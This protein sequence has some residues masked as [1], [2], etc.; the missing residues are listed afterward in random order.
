M[1]TIFL[2]F[3]ISQ[4]EPPTISINTKTGEIIVGMIPFEEVTSLKEQMFQMPEKE[5]ENSDIP[6]VQT[7]PEEHPMFQFQTLESPMEKILNP[8]NL[9]QSL[10]DAWS[11]L[12][13][14]VHQHQTKELDSEQIKKLNADIKMHSVDTLVL[15]DVL[16]DENVVFR[17][18][19]L[20]PSAGKKI[21][22][23]LLSIVYNLSIKNYQHAV[24]NMVRISHF[25]SV[26]TTICKDSEPF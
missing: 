25:I 16:H 23:E 19:H 8:C 24:F 1:L 10:S 12:A 13:G 9:L 4:C 18:K 5:P 20:L 17:A 22:R 11:T 3:L 14:V 7:M 15:V 26:V 21:Y 2:S 6:K